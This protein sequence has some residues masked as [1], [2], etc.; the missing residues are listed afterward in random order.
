M[1]IN[2]R[3]KY[4]NRGRAY[5][6]TDVKIP[7]NFDV[8]VLELFC[9]YVLSENQHIRKSHL[10]NMR[11]LLSILDMDNYKNDPEKM[12][13]LDFIQKGL[14]GKLEHNIKNPILLLKYINGGIMD[15]DIID[16]NDMTLLS[17]DEL[18]WINQTITETLKYRF[19]YSN[20]D[21][22][23]ELYT[24][25][26]AS[27]YTSVGDIVKEFEAFIDLMKGEFRRAKVDRMEDMT[28]TLRPG[29]FEETMQDVYD[30][31]MNPS[32]RLLTGLQ[33]LNEMTNGG[34]ESGRVYMFLGMTGVGKSLLLLNIIYE[35]KKANKNYKPKDPTKIP[36]IVMLT[37]E[38]TVRETIQRLWDVVGNTDDMTNYDIE[39]IIRKLTT[40]GELYLSADSPIDI[41]VKY[42]SNRSIDTGYLY[43]LCEDLE[44]EGYEVI[45][46][47]QD[48]VKRIR[49]AYPQTDLRIELGEVVNEMKV[50]AAIKDIPVITVSHLNRDAAKTIDA[51]A[52]GNKADITRMLGKANTGESLLML[53]N[54][55]CAFVINVEYDKD[56]HKYMVFKRIKMRDKS[57]ARDYLAYPFVWD[58]PAR[59]I[60]D[61]DLDV[62]IFKESLHELN[63][64]TT[65]KVKPSAYSNVKALEYDD[66]EEDENDGGIFER[67]STYSSDNII[68]L[69][70]YNEE[71]E[72]PILES[73]P[74]VASAVTYDMNG[75]IMINP[76]SFDNALI[77]KK[78]Q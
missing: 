28:F 73:V 12:S 8:N 59:I 14:E 57:S 66:F 45:A 55:D 43:T 64:V 40:E 42:K 23:Y 29:Q 71:E 46:L 22:I 51:G 26:K 78:Q 17:T 1:N 49:S 67:M 4:E 25:F 18:E 54:L 48:H 65:G 19:V 63:N 6:K 11:N 50:F 13:R 7:T 36:V 32:R 27:D 60:E 38:N 53:D 30:Q 70:S 15:S 76:I 33:G 77:Q 58:N 62:P 39:E 68:P 75:K 20:I 44:D 37:Q 10:I 72:A 74:I 24:R 41:V 16:I 52:V 9:I 56:S 34:F 47:F 69:P 35:M 2:R 5:I 3:V 31:L 21:Y 61:I